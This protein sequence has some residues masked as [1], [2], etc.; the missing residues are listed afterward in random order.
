M[1]AVSAP[2]KHLIAL[3]YRNKR[4]ELRLEHDTGG[5]RWVGAPPVYT[6][7][8]D[9]AKTRRQIKRQTGGTTTH[10]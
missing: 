2:G 10:Y 5:D 1:T 3:S 9:G 8:T 7:Y 4:N 6:G